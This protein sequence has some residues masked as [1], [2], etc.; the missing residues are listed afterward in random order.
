MATNNT[1]YTPTE[2]QGSGVINVPGPLGDAFSSIFREYENPQWFQDLIFDPFATLPGGGGWKDPFAKPGYRTPQSLESTLLGSQIFAFDPREWERADQIAAL[3]MENLDDKID[4]EL[5]QDK[6]SRKL[7]EEILGEQRDKKIR[8]AEMRMDNTLTQQDQQKAQLRLQALQTM[9]QIDSLIGQSGLRSGTYDKRKEVALDSVK[10]DLQKANLTKA[11]SIRDY[12]KAKDSAISDY[13][14]AL[15]KSNAAK[16]AQYNT[17]LL[18]AEQKKETLALN[19]VADKI[20]VYEDWQADQVMTAGQIQA[21]GEHVYGTASERLEAFEKGGEEYEIMENMYAD[22][23]D[24]F[25]SWKLE[26]AE[27]YEDMLAN[28]DDYGIQSQYR[29]WRNPEEVRRYGPLINLPFHGEPGVG[30]D[31]VG[32]IGGEYMG[33]IEGG[34][35]LHDYSKEDLDVNIMNYLFL[36]GTGLDQDAFREEYGEWSPWMT[37]KMGGD[38]D[39]SEFG[40]LGVTYWLDENWDFLDKPGDISNQYVGI[41]DDFEDR[42]EDWDDAD[43]AEWEAL[44]DD[45]DNKTNRQKVGLFWNFYGDRGQEYWESLTDEQRQA[46]FDTGEMP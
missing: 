31:V 1:A 41:Y 12:N 18:N 38:T 45:W 34:W 25:D 2:L 5:S 40:D 44:T 7:D 46:Y 42:T 28:P 20:K 29:T 36:T 24:N 15:L 4:L 43:W 33:T 10:A 16:D 27:L 13:D 22:F 30:L 21:T 26:N 39:L 37:L 8:D 14:N 17:S 6:R 19:L 32:S 9:S 35:D 11:M 23:A 3:S